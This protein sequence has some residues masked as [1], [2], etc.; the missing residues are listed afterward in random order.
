MAAKP[1]KAKTLRAA[2]RRVRELLKQVAY[3]KERLLSARKVV[4][5]RLVDS[6][7]LQQIRTAI[8][9]AEGRS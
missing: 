4:A 6:L 7:V 2:E 1:Y 8:E 5:E 9:Q 3:L